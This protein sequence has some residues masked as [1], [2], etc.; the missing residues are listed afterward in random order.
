MKYVAAYNLSTMSNTWVYDQNLT[1]DMYTRVYWHSYI[2][3]WN[4]NT[5]NGL[6]RMF[7]INPKETLILS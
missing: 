7:Y 4:W 1:D 6:K 5:Q 2:K 3:T